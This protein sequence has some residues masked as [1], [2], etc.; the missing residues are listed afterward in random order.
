MNMLYDLTEAAGGKWEVVREA[1]I[2]DPRIG[3]SHTDPVHGGGRGAGGHCFIKDFEAFRKLYDTIV[4][5]PGGSVLLDAQIQKNIA[6]LQ[7]SGKDSELLR[8]VYGDIFQ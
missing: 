6:L 1:M 7:Q 2:N 8:G 4:D 5:D 3:D